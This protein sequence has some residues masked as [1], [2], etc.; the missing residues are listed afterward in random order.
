MSDDHVM[1]NG[2]RINVAGE[3]G[4]RPLFAQVPLEWAAKVAKQTGTQR[5]FV[6]MYLGFLAWQTGSTT[7]P[8]PNVRLQRYGISP[9]TKNRA[10]RD[11][12]L[13]RAI[14]VERQPRKRPVVTM[15]DFPRLN[16]SVMWRKRQSGE[17]T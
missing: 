17:G 13:V 10:L 6:W 4:K 5:A 11:L 3:G 2:R 16:K 1:R 12:E 8:V 9:K 7:F 15:K 14:S